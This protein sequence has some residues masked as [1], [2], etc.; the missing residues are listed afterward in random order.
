MTSPATECARKPRLLILTTTFPRWPDDHQPP[1]VFELARRLTT[2]FDIDVLAPHAP[3]AERRELMNGLQIHRFRYAPARLELLAYDGGIPAKL[4]RSPLYGLLLPGFLLAQAWA[5]W[6]L[7]RLRRHVA[8]HA[9]WLIPQGLWGGMF[10]GCVR[11]PARLLVTAHGAD[12]FAF[13]GAPGRWLKAR[14]LAMADAVSVVSRALQQRVLPLIDHPEHLHVASMG[15]DLAERFVPAAVPV[16]APVLVFAG[17]LVEKKGLADLLA[18]MPQ[19]LTTQ[20]DARLLVIGDGPLAPE[21]RDQAKRLGIAD[22]VEFLGSLPN[23]AVPEVLRRGRLAVLPFRPAPGD[24]EGL[25]LVAVEAMGC[26]LPVVAGDVPAIRDVIRHGH[27]GWLVPSADPAALASAIL[28]LLGDPALAEQ[29]ARQGR[30]DA[31]GRFDWAVVTER[32]R[33]LLSDEPVPDRRPA[34]P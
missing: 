28:Q 20:P 30:H 26:G 2:H 25:G 18:A 1:F 27:N 29:L 16:S 23:A 15:A 34:Q 33:R 3:G 12:I 6:R 9:H 7:L 31:L 24:E 4:R 17:R 10:K 13:N 14:A 22:A 5:T 11:P 8:I 32:Y 19:V 21:L